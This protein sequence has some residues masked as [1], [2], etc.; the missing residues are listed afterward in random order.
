[1]AFSFT[2]TAVDAYGNVATGFRGTIT[3][4]SF[5]N[6]DILPSPYTFTA[7]DKGVH[8]FV[9]QTTMNTR[10]TDEIIITDFT[11]NVGNITVITVG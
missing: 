2:I 6:N 9:K 11:D 7:A 4:S 5:D 8:T 1:V 3:F 10:G